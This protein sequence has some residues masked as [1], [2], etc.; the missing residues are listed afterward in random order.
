MQKSIDLQDYL[1]YGTGLDYK[2]V[3]TT[4]NQLDSSRRN[5]QTQQV[6]QRDHVEKVSLQDKIKKNTFITAN[7]N[8]RQR[9]DEIERQRLVKLKRLDEELINQ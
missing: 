5:V 8:E 4:K 1:N 9:L 6:S 2:K 7:D 3:T